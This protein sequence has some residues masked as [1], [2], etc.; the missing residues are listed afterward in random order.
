MKPVAFSY[1]RATTIENSLAMLASLGEDAKIIAGGQSLGPMLNYRIARPTNLVE[2]RRIAA[3]QDVR[4][5]SNGIAIGAAV[6]HSIIED[7]K[8][9][10][11]IERFLSKVAGGIAYRAIRNRGT[12]GGSLAHADPSADWP[13]VIS[14]LNADIEIQSAEGTRVVSAREFFVGQ[15]E[16]VLAPNE[17]L[18][19]VRILE[20]RPQTRYGYY[21]AVR[22]TGEFADSISAVCIDVDG[23]GAVSEA[24]VWLGA[25]LTTPCQLTEVESLLTGRRATEW[26]QDQV[27]DAVRSALPQ[28]E[29]DHERYKSQ[30]H[31]VTVLRALKQAIEVS[32]DD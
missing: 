20:G 1:H 4:R 24:H 27:F 32:H 30:L 15:M 31:C 29:N 16:T 12:I 10:F 7:W 18:I 5:D 11:R 3:L 2:V 13:V 9:S 25:A 6:S 21:K 28:P 19:E 22:K 23:E 14:A 26:K 8:G 17:M